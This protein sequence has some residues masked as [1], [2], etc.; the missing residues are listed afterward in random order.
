MR[1]GIAFRVASDLRPVRVVAVELARRAIVRA[2][3]LVLA[4]QQTIREVGERRRLLRA[5]A[6][7]HRAGPGHTRLA[8]LR[9]LHLGRITR[10][11][12]EQRDDEQ[13]AH[14]DEPRGMNPSDPWDLVVALAN[15][16]RAVGVAPAGHPH[17]QRP[18]SS[19]SVTILKNSGACCFTASRRPPSSARAF[20]S[21]AALSS[22]V[23]GVGAHTGGMPLPS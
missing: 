3:L 15:A 23:S 22:A 5:R 10:E 19:S 1:A 16:M 18:N 2:Q 7:G 6:P 4:R 14:H 8:G 21:A 17:Q 11:Q 13:C 9:L 20:A 12:E